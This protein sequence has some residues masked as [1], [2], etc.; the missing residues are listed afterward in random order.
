MIL[1][2]ALILNVPVF[3]PLAAGLA[4]WCIGRYSEKARDR[5]V[6]LT[7]LL[8]CAVMVWIAVRY[9]SH[10]IHADIS[11]ICGLGLHFMT[12]GFRVLYGLLT[13][14]MWLICAVF[15]KEYMQNRENR[16]RYYLF[17]LLTLGAAQGV[18]LAADLYTVFIFFEL[19]SFTSYVW[20]AQEET[21]DALR[22]AET[23]LGAAVIGGMVTLMGLFLLYQQSGTLMIEELNTACSG[24]NAYIAAVCIFI[25]FG[26]K[27]GTFPLHFTLPKAYPA[28]PTPESALLSAILSKNGLVGILIIS[29]Q[30]LLHD[31]L[32]GSFVL[33]VGVLTMV[34][35]A[36]LALFSIELK[37]TLACSSVSQIGFILVGIGMQ[38]MLETENALAVQGTF[39]H[40]LNHSLFKLVLFLAAG[41]VLMHTKKHDLNDIQGFGRNKPLLAAV[42]LCGGLGISSIPLFSGYISKTLLH[43][44]ITEYYALLRAGQVSGY[45]TAGSIKAI[46]WLFLI[47][48]GLTVAYMCKLFVVLFVEKNR[49][50]AVQQQYDAVGK[51]YLS[52]KSAVL[53]AVSAGSIPLFGS[54]P[55]LFLDHAADF[56]KEYFAL[57][58]I[59]RI[60]Y[61]SLTN[62]GGAC[63]SIVIGIVLYLTVVRRV[64]VKN[65]QYRALFPKWLDLENL[66]FRQV[67]LRLLPAVCGGICSLLD[68]I[69]DIT[70]RV[71]V[72]LGGA[73]ASFLDVGVDTIVVILRKTVYRDSPQP[74]EPEEGN[75]MTNF[76]GR[77]VNRI[78]WILNLSVRR[79]NPNTTDYTHRYALAYESFKENTSLISRSLS[80]GLIL[81]CIG[82]LMTLIYLFV[83]LRSKGF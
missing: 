19:L 41:V 29:C 72:M 52:K 59:H 4:C 53:L 36:V 10:T 27:A 22:A 77:I 60:A 25:G 81:F 68:R 57:E 33:L 2:G 14:W 51:H 28:A 58:H 13:A 16:N 67:L 43:E 82:L 11:N 23:Y 46:E 70:A 8:E 12:D 55:H 20:V 26:V 75:V 50:T 65:G 49:D 7:V 71:L 3:F 6:T 62:L 76:F 37:H 40:M 18:F 61:F 24:K 15:S 31:A 63:I 78:M 66:L 79:N 83:V 69:T 45:L 34:V 42:F 73:A 1:Q 80:Y 74:T 17:F 44:S 56:A 35:G 48:G 64:I 38:G 30:I 39:L 47:S 9:G 54:L 21:Q 5:C 32:W